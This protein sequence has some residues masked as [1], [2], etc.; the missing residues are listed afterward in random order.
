MCIDYLQILNHFVQGT[1]EN[2]Q[3]LISCRS[4][5][6]PATPCMDPEGGN[7]VVH[8]LSTNLSKYAI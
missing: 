5:G 1:S 3:I 8:C 7:K 4:R 2:S 6:S